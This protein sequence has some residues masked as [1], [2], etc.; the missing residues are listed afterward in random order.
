MRTKN[1]ILLGIAATS[2]VVAS[3]GAAF[4]LY[5][6][7]KNADEFNIGIGSVKSITSSTD[8]VKYKIGTISTYS[9]EE[10]KT[11]VTSPKISP[12]LKKVYVKVPLGFEN[13]GNRT[14]TNSVNQDY[15]TCT[16][17]V[18]IKANE[19]LVDLGNVKAT[20][21]LQGY[22]T[23]ATNGDVNSTYFSEYKQSNFVDNTFS[24][25]DGKFDSTTNTI[26]RY[27]D[28]GID[29]DSTVYCVIG[30]DLSSALDDTNMNSSDSTKNFLSLA[31][32]SGAFSITLS[33]G[34]YDDGTGTSTRIKDDGENDTKV[35]RDIDTN[36]NPDLWITGDKNGWKSDEINNDYQLVP[37][38]KGAL[39]SESGDAKVEWM[40]AGIT[41]FSQLKVYD[42][43]LESKWISCRNQTTEDTKNPGVKSEDGGNAV[44]TIKDNYAYDV[45]YK[46]G[47]TD[48]NNKGFWVSGSGTA[49]QIQ[50]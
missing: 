15:A 27:I 35:V 1:K 21:K 18:E 23:L 16:L 9:D 12:D 43:T 28:T 38:L 32:L 25:T 41:N 34:E 17:K 24:S 29:K 30:L 50:N 14:D 36:L 13:P 37:N 42:N 3:F 11:S 33:L 5:N 48:E 22:S 44:L 46:R 7:T 49:N 40:Y 6:N 4:A 45:Y 47:A 10:C 8:E 19:K 31:N 20:A 39:Y 26:T 2:G